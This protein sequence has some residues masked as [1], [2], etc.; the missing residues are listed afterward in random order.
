MTKR[1]IAAILTIAMLLSMQAIIPVGAEISGDWEY[2][3]SDGEATINRYYGSATNVTIPNEIDG[4]PVTGLS[5]WYDSGYYGI[6]YGKS[7]TSV[8]IPDSVTTIGSDAFYGCTSLTSVTIPD[9]V[10]SIGYSAF[11]Y[12]TSLTSIDVDPNNA[13]YRSIDGLLFS[14]DASILISCPGVKTSVTIPDSVTEIGQLAFFGCTSLATVNYPGSEASW[15]RIIIRTNNDPLTTAEKVYNYHTHN[16]E[17]TTVLPTCTETGKTIFV[18]S[19]CGDSYTVDEVPALGHD[20]SEWV[21]FT[22]P[23]C[24]AN[25][26]EF[27]CCLN[28]GSHIVI[29]PVAPTGHVL[30]HVDS[31]APKCESAGNIEHWKC[32]NCRKLFANANGDNELE[33]R[34]VLLAALG[35]SWSDWFA[36]VEP[37]YTSS[38]LNVRFCLNDGSHAEYNE[39]QVEVLLDKMNSAKH[40]EFREIPQLV[41]DAGDLNGDRTINSRDVIALLRLI[42]GFSDGD[43]LTAAADYDGNGRVNARDVIAVMKAALAEVT[44]GK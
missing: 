2:S 36:L 16:Y 17:A 39:T 42:V 38:G 7:T 20:W 14:K 32:E 3:V 5:Y 44:A 40:V 13:I 34:D 15:N 27:R 22:D 30:S 6:F 33:Q 8:T 9:S 18:C 10:T 21:R 29:R 19:I 28:D 26:Y 35:H 25:G 4:Y 1:I 41:P 31:V 23:S 37:T 24:T 43:T 11:S 12:C